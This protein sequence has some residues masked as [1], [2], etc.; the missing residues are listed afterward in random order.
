MPAECHDEELVYLGQLDEIVQKLQE[1]A[2]M[3]NY[4]LNPAYDPANDIDAYF[5]CQNSVY[6]D[7]C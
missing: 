4:L 2:D 3:G 1:N 6:A 7:Y 5:C